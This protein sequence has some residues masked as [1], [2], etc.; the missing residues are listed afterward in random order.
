[1][2]PTLTQK[3]DRFRRFCQRRGWEYA[4]ETLFA[5]VGGVFL[6]AVW[7]DYLL[8]REFFFQSADGRAFLLA[9]AV[10]FWGMLIGKLW[11]RLRNVPKTDAELIRTLRQR[12]ASRL[13]ESLESALWFARHPDRSQESAELRQTVV[14]QAENNVES[15]DF[16]RSFTAFAISKTRT[17]AM[18]TGLALLGTL[19]LLPVGGTRFWIP[20][21]PC[22]WDIPFAVTWK[23]LPREV[24]EG[25][26]F[27]AELVPPRPYRW[28]NV[29]VEMEGNALIRR[30]RPLD[31]RYFLQ[32]PNVRTS[33]TLTP[34][35]EGHEDLRSGAT[36]VTVRP[37]PKLVGAEFH[38]VPPE[39]S[40]RLPYAGSWNLDDLPDSR[41]GLLIRVSQPLE[42]A[43]IVLADGKRIPA[44]PYR[45]VGWLFAWTLD[46]A[47]T[48]HLELTNTEGLKNTLETWTMRLRRDAVPEGKLESPP[49]GR[50]VLPGVCLPL[51]VRAW[52]DFGLDYVGFRWLAENP[53]HPVASR[54]PRWTNF[55]LWTPEKETATPVAVLEKDV[56]YRWKTEPLALSAGTTLRLQPVTQDTPGGLG[57]GKEITLYVVTPAEMNRRVTQEWVVVTQE[58]QQMAAHVQAIRENAAR[59]AD[60]MAAMENLT[61]QT[62]REL[63]DCFLPTLDALTRDVFDH[64]Q[65]S[66]PV[67]KER[68]ERLLAAWKKLE[69]ERLPPL[70]QA[71]TRA[72]REGGNGEQVAAF[73]QAVLEILEPLVQE[74]QQQ[75][76]D[77]AL[78]ALREEIVGLLEKLPTA[79]ETTRTTRAAEIQEKTNRYFRRYHELHDV[80]ESRAERELQSESV[81]ILE[82]AQNHEAVCTTSLLRH[83]EMWN[84]APMRQAR[85]MLEEGMA[86][87]EIILRQ[88]P[89][90]NDALALFFWRSEQQKLAERLRNPET[91]L[92]VS[93]GILFDEL[94][95]QVSES[96]GKWNAFRPENVAAYRAEQETLRERFRQLRTQLAQTSDLA[97]RIS[98]RPA[99]APQDAPQTSEK[100]KPF[101]AQAEVHAADVQVLITLQQE[102]LDQT[103]TAGEA[104]IPHLE[105]LENR[106]LQI[107][108]SSGFRSNAEGLF[109][110]ILSKMNQVAFLFHEGE[111]GPMNTHLQEEILAELIECL[112][113]QKEDD[114]SVSLSSGTPEKSGDLSKNVDS[115]AAEGGTT[116]TEET[117]PTETPKDPIYSELKTGLWGELPERV[118]RELEQTSPENRLP[119]YE[120]RLEAYWRR[121]L[122]K[123]GNESAL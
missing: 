64:P 63:A 21:T 62:N 61:R 87:Q 112:Q 90:I 113:P 75:A 80:P 46:E 77:A 6:S 108:Q 117:P 1:M 85:G 106:I 53:N 33:F 2:K 39:Y 17:A 121:L 66:L 97:S 50:P 26:T 14:E 27:L 32:I 37:L 76:S 41:V 31:G 47:T 10:L 42:K 44:K 71:V 7:L 120:K 65:A 96:A 103:P 9:A 60:A 74:W 94:A 68:L 83:W 28:V 45:D 8:Y 73:A 29:R 34:F 4:L 72:V 109:A 57:E 69:T 116:T 19:P 84:A 122:Q 82:K 92:P 56:S 119:E 23:T 43:E 35:P 52:D 107:A 100:E 99:K 12:D 13:P 55:L 51:V 54:T 78:E 59:P 115:R 114:P 24:T 89:E 30:V 25:E 95:G 49:D 110:D 102:V 38:I 40:G 91:K 93:V 3:F 111:T 22:V 98:N 101:D 5:A 16:R 20:W 67:P 36:Y 70:L 105:S 79:D 15:L 18:L 58:F 11:K 123:S 48:Y 81:W 104:E 118:R 88:M 86:I